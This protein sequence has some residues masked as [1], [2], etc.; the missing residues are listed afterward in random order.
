MLPVL[1]LKQVLGIMQLSQ[2]LYT[3]FLLSPAKPPLLVPFLSCHDSFLPR[4]SM[5]FFQWAFSLHTFLTA[6]LMGVC[7]AGLVLPR[8][9]LLV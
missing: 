9:T 2:T 8:H 6:E 1:C 4:M 3:P 5:H 7:T